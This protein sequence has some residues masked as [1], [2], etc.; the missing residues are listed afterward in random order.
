MT[1]H[2]NPENYYSEPISDQSYS[3]DVDGYFLKLSPD[4]ELLWSTYF[5]TRNSISDDKVFSI[6][7]DGGNR[8]YFTGWVDLDQDYN[9]SHTIPY[10]EYSLTSYDYFQQYRNGEPNNNNEGFWGYFDSLKLENTASI[11]QLSN[12][13]E[14]KMLVYPNPS[15]TIITLSNFELSSAVQVDILN[16]YS[17]TVLTQKHEGKRVITVDIGNLA[18]EAYLVRLTDGKKWNVTKIIKQ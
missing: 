15:N 4:C 5:F 13:L 2:G 16:I 6:A 8:L 3:S 11:L 1:Y 12:S 7:S 17:Q 10:Q 9:D 18:Q 14:D